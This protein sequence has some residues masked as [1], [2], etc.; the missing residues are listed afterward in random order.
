M[1]AAPLPLVLFTVTRSADA[2]HCDAGMRGAEWAVGL[3]LDGVADGLGDDDLVPPG[4]ADEADLAPDDPQAATSAATNAPPQ[5]TA[6]T[7]AARL[8]AR[9]RMFMSMLPVFAESDVFKLLDA[10]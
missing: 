6:A 1:P 2:G 10:A 9:E 4:V 3:L 8:A 5:L 7:V